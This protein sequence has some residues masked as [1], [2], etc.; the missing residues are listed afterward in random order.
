[1]MNP[2]QLG[3][4]L[5]HLDGAIASLEHARHMADSPAP[6]AEDKDIQMMISSFIQAAKNERAR[7]SHV[8][9]MRATE[10]A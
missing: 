10:P 4:V 9:L 7:I 5:S 8:K 1:M 3:Y 6:N 2:Q